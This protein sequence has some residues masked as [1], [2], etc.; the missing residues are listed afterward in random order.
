M[1]KEVSFYVSFLFLSL[2]LLPNSVIY[3]NVY[4]LIA[5]SVRSYAIINIAQFE[6]TII[7]AY[8]TEEFI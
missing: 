6:R 2:A 5:I 4:G 7:S 1:K 3:Y 8:T